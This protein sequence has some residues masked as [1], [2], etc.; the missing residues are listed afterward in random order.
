MINYFTWKSN[1]YSEHKFCFLSQWM[2]AKKIAKNAILF[3]ILGTKLFA[4][5]FFKKFL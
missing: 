5:N 3:V 1:N 4:D 2:S